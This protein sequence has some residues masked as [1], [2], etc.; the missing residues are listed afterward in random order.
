M[1]PKLLQLD[2]FNITKKDWNDFINNPCFTILLTKLINN[3][4]SDNTKREQIESIIEEIE[5]LKYYTS[6]DITDKD[7]EKFLKLKTELIKFLD[8]FFI[9]IQEI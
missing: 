1:I 4:Y 6:E 7:I 5:N 3:M 9:Q 8:V 2:L